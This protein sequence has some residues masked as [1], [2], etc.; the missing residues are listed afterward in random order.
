MRAAV[1]RG[2][3][4]FAVEDMPAPGCPAG[5][6]LLEVAACS[7]CGTDARIVAHG[8]HAVNPPQILGH[9]LVGRV[10]EADAP[11][12]APGSRVTVAPAVGCGACRFCRAGNTNRCPSLR[13][14]G[15]QFQ[16]AFAE[17]LP[18]PAEAVAQ[19]HVTAVPDHLP[20][21][22]AALC[23]PLACCLNGQSLVRLS[24]GE[25]AV[26]VG[27]GPI[28]L[29]HALLARQAGASVLLLEARHER[30]ERAAALGVGELLE[31]AG[32]VAAQIRARTD[33]VGAD[34]VIVAAPSAAAQ[35][36][37]LAWLAPGGRVSLFGG[38]PPGDSAVTFDANRI[39]YP[40]VA[41]VGAHASTAAHNRAALALL[42]GPLGAAA[43]RLVTACYP[44]ER[45]AEAVA[46]AA[47]GAG[48]KALVRIA[49]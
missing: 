44:L 25:V 47:R 7:V 29:L 43:A 8:H 40:E 16:G 34:V 49:P 32:D 18:V 48:L 3:G 2:P 38:L 4:Q 1:Y 31:P 45:A 36:A 37:S 12:F 30:R 24:A 15:Y 39:H 21:A 5:G 33:G 46:Q 11:G 13:T 9:E 6:L 42:A 19:G 17:V 14:I 41:V 10:R 23:E 27:C 20:D 35:S 28:G 26:I 22:V